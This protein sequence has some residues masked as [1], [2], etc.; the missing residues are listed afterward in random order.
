MSLPEPDRGDIFLLFNDM[1]YDFSADLPL[2]IGKGVCL[3]TTPQEWLDAL[4]QG[5]ADYLLPGYSLLGVGLNNCCLRCFHRPNPTEELRQG[6][7]FSFQCL[8]FVCI[9]QLRSILVANFVWVEIT[10]VFGIQHHTRWHQ[11]GTKKT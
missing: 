1:P 11:V 5:L 3:D 2:P 6:T 4:E 8:L 10:I 9:L 7:Y